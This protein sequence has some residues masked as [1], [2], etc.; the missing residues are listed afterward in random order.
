MWAPVH[1][2]ALVFLCMT[3]FAPPGH[4]GHSGSVFNFR[5]LTAAIIT[6]YFCYCAPRGMP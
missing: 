1:I 6:G 5:S 4:S 2:S 3:L